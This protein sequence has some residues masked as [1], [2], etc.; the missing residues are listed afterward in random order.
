ML[1]AI[2]V[3]FIVCTRFSLSTQII[4]LPSKGN[5]KMAVLS[6]IVDGIQL[7]LP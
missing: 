4:S 7:L 5:P 2:V 1:T 3:I 6:E